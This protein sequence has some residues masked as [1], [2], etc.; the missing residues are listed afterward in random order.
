MVAVSLVIRVKNHLV[1]L[2]RKEKGKK[3]DK[4]KERNL[5]TGKKTEDEKIG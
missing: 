1:D 2:T 3:S 5:V 4:E